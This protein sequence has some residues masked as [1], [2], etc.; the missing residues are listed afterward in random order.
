MGRTTKSWQMDPVEWVFR[1]RWIIG[2]FDFSRG[3]DDAIRNGVNQE[4]VSVINVGFL[5]CKEWMKIFQQPFLVGWPDVTYHCN[6]IREKGNSIDF[7]FGSCSSDRLNFTA[8]ID[9]PWEYKKSSGRQKKVVF[10]MQASRGSGTLTR[11][12]RWSTYL[13]TLC[14]ARYLSRGKRF[15]EPRNSISSDHGI[16]SW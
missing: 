13:C 5:R 3:D 4:Q 8:P 6:R 9:V 11:P 15:F 10:P 2:R 12:I 1:N 16:R 7:A 14:V